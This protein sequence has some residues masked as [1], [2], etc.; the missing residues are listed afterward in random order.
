MRGKREIGRENGAL[1]LVRNVREHG[2]VWFISTKIPDA[3]GT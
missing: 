3:S 1:T 2:V